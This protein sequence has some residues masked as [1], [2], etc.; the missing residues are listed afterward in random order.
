[1]LKIFFLRLSVL[2][3]DYEDTL[4]DGKH[5]EEIKMEQNFKNTD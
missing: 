1:M 3:S 5:V 4:L 2:F